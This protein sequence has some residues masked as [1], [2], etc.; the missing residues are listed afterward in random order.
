MRWAQ[1]GRGRG[2]GQPGT[3]PS[4]LHRRARRDHLPR[5][6]PGV[7]IVT[8][9]GG[10]FA[11]HLGRRRHV[12]GVDQHLVGARGPHGLGQGEAGSDGEGPDALGRELDVAHVGDP[13]EGRLGRRV[14]HTPAAPAG[15]RRRRGE[16]GLGEHVDQAAL[17]A[18]EH[19]GQDEL[20]Q[21][22]GVEV[23]AD[24]AAL[25]QLQGQVQEPVHR[26]GPLVDGVVDQ[27]V[28]AAEGGERRLGRPFDRRAVHEVHRDGDAGPSE[29][30]DGGSGRLEA[31]GDRNRL[32]VARASSRRGRG[33][34]PR[35][36]C[37]R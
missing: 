10:H 29:R 27:H 30:L 2:G 20:G 23:V 24:E 16:G 18:L 37:G 4:S 21:Q 25:G 6:A 12:A 32:V 33:R 11:G 28:D 13:V 5:V 14:G 1:A 26:P 22:E 36:P 19:A 34:R 17:A 8:Q 35:A 3:S 9:P 15:G 31:A 7:G